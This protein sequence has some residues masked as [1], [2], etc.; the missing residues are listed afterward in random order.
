M[1]R[2]ENSRNQVEVLLAV[3]DLKKVP[4]PKEIVESVRAALAGS[5]SYD[6]EWQLSYEDLTIYGDQ[7]KLPTAS[8]ESLEAMCKSSLESAHDILARMASLS[9][10]GLAPTLVVRF[11]N[12]LTEDTYTKLLALSTPNL[13]VWKQGLYVGAIRNHSDGLPDCAKT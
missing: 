5:G 1:T 4:A 6:L 3:M 12:G 11:P 10:A 9:S 2:I 8:L 7:L 13:F